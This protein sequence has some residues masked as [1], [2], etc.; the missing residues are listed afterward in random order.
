MVDQPQQPPQQPP[1]APPPPY[2]YYP[3]TPGYP[4]PYYQQQQQQPQPTLFERLPWKWKILIGLALL[5]LVFITMMQSC[6]SAMQTNAVR[7]TPA[8]TAYPRDPP[9]I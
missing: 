8:N 7:R 3:P 2:G 4:P 5:A 9:A 6:Q 1:Q